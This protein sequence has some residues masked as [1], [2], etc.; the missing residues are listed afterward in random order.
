MSLCFSRVDFGKKN[1]KKTHRASHYFLSKCVYSKKS[2]N[3]RFLPK[4]GCLVKITKVVATSVESV[5]ILSL[6]IKAVT[7]WQH[8]VKVTATHGVTVSQKP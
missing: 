4:C 1:K 3:K 7:G 8:V 5:V 6:L 2:Q